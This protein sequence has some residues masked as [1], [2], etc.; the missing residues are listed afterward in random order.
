[1]GQIG[2]MA[3]IEIPL[4]HST[5]FSTASSDDQKLVGEASTGILKNLDGEKAFHIWHH[6]AESGA[7]IRSGKCGR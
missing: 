7:G 6:L 3:G 1:M 4:L 5:A 2:T